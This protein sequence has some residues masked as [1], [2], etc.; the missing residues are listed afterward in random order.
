MSMTGRPRYR[1][2]SRLPPPSSPILRG[3]DEAG[4]PSA[5]VVLTGVVLTSV[6]NPPELSTEVFTQRRVRS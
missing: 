2:G 4:L 1:P 5:S 6:Q 3:E